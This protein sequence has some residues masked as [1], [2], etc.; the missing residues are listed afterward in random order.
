MHLGQL[1]HLVAAAAFAVAA[2]ARPVPRGESSPAVLT[3]QAHVRSR[4]L[5]RCAGS[6]HG[7]RP[8]GGR[9]VLHQQYQFYRKRRNLRWR[10]LSGSA[11][12]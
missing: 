9:I 7:L 1:W 11:V 8:V 4:C 10:L 3:G 5:V 12:G 6:A 2:P